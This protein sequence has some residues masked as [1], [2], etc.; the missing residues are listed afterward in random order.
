MTD[1]KFGKV[2]GFGKAACR[3]DRINGSLRG[4]EQVLRVTKARLLD[5]GVQGHPFRMQKEGVEIVRVIAHFQS[6]RLVVDRV[7]ELMLYVI[8]DRLD[9]RIQ[10]AAMLFAAAQMD[11]LGEN[12]FQKRRFYV[13]C[14]GRSDSV[15][16]VHILQNR[17]QLGRM[18]KMKDLFKGR[19]AAL[20]D[21]L[22][23]RKDLD[24]IG[25]AWGKGGMRVVKI[26][27][28]NKNFGGRVICKQAIANARRNGDHGKLLE[29]NA[30]L[31]LLHRDFSL[32]YVEQTE[33]I[34]IDG[35]RIGMGETSVP[36]KAY[37]GI[38]F[39]LVHV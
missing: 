14:G 31:L 18:R 23:G 26:E 11:R 37:K 19:N 17:L 7:R 38:E 13:C 5:V 16:L 3:G 15:P 8:L 29:L 20:G 12:V 6:D 36:A 39:G 27:I 32:G 10:G 22:G 9:L 25:R 28:E 35:M 1:E 21:D 4:H 30:V 33:I 2:G 24:L 34:G